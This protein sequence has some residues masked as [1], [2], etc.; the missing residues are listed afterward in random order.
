MTEARRS[1]LPWL[2]WGGGVLMLAATVTL[3]AINDSLS[4]DPY[5]VPLAVAMILG[6]PTVGAVLASR[7]P[8]NPIGWLMIAIGIAFVFTGVSSEYLTYVYETAPRPDPAFGP[9]VALLSDM[10]WLPIMGGLALLAVLFPTGRVPGPRWR[11]L[12]WTLGTA[13]ALAALGTALNPSP[14]ED[15]GLDVTL[16]SPFGVEALGRV[17]EI[18]GGAGAVVVVFLSVPAAIAA[19]VLRY[20]RSTGEERQQIRWLAYVAATL[21]VVVVAGI[22]TALVMG[23]SY[24]GSPAADLFFIVAFALIGIGVPVAMG[25][26]VL[27]YRL[28]E[29]DVVVKKT[30]VFGVLVVLLMAVSVGT[31]LALSSPLTDLAPDETQAVG[32]TGLIVG[33]SVW[34]LWRLARRI[35]DRIVYGGRATPYEV[36]TEFS[37]RV[38]ETYSTEDVL[39]RMAQL[40][41]E[42]TGALVARVWV[43]VG[44][45]LRPAQTWPVDADR[46]D[47]IRLPDDTLPDFHATLGE[48]GI[49]V[50]HQGELLGALSVQM[51]A[52]DPMG[53]GRQRIVHDLAS[54]AGLV[55]RNVRLIEELRESRRRIVAAQ[56]DRRK[57]LERDIHDG[58]QQQL[59]A[60]S[61][62]ARLAGGLAAKDP[63][64]TEEMLEDL[65][66][67]LTE[68]LEN[69]RDLA[70]GIYP[71][72]LADRGL[73]AALEAQARKSPTPVR[74]D[75][76]GVGRFPPETE[77][78]VYFSVL[79][80]LQNVAKYAHATSATVRLVVGDRA[81]HF[82]VADDGRGFDATGTSFGT[83]LL[84]IVD[85]LSALGGEVEIASTP[86]SGTTVRGRLP[87]TRDASM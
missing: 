70:R 24:D 12:P 31:L 61:V 57:K 49:E 51:A 1:R 21:V 83:G 67:D 19:L 43:R 37:E 64:R 60:L 46:V 69:L 58:A 30:I 5:F 54:Q 86:G 72:L 33:L 56:D 44:S 40:L 32:L 25:V 13:M 71:P 22:V 36:L 9:V 87:I 55:L 2:L 28:Y 82:E 26:A 18:L 63:A 41:G 34:P 74:V 62:K 10:L 20:R 66:H 29:L 45:E 73:S 81:L 8:A 75:A 48:H 79:E 76:D 50:R 84:G 80:A 68:A 27:K 85:R 77:T 47:P 14:F 65:Q 38:G 16:S 39:P 42:A 4:E 11:F 35:A 78:T 23:P 59:V 3:V 15:L 52:S 7:N 6:Y 17:P 53:A